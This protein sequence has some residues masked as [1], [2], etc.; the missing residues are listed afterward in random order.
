M[1]ER[2]VKYQYFQ[3]KSIQK[4][5]NKWSDKPEVFYLHDWIEKVENE[6]LLKKKVDVNRC[7]IRIDHM[8]WDR[9]HKIWCL[10]FLR[11]RDTNIPAKVKDYQDAKDIE[12]ES[13]E[14]IG[15]GI[16]VLYDAVSG[17]TMIQMNKF[18]I[19]VGKLAEFIT[20]TFDKENYR[21]FFEPI[22]DA[23]IFSEVL[24][25][26]VTKIT[27]GFANIVDLNQLSEGA[28]TLRS[29]VHPMKK[30]GGF[31]GNISIG[32]GHL[33]KKYLDKIE[34]E[35][36][37]NELLENQHLLSVAKVSYRDDDMART[38]V[39]DLFDKIECDYITYSIK[40]KKSLEYTEAINAMISLYEKRKSDLYSLMGFT[41]E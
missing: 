41:M 5:N 4:I 3:V 26:D 14:Y 36:I 24:K 11:L 18:S 35:R 34:V 15:D 32:V 30:I 2:T 22:A 10:R 19:G 28:S 9:L 27:I 21:I 37:A 13:D 20:H 6:H 38:E 7:L 16:D 31:V 40:P 12:L 17:I 29:I 39:I 1:Y 8:N 23:S 25:N 33:K